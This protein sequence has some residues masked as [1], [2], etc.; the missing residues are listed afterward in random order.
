MGS[1]PL[2]ENAHIPMC[3]SE[4]FVQNRCT[5]YFFPFC[6]VFPRLLGLVRVEQ[7]LRVLAQNSDR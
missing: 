5:F 3:T 4:A 1:R 6:L 2:G 7:A